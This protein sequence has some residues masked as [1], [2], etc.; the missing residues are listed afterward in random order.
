MVLLNVDWPW[1]M[2]RASLVIDN[3]VVVVLQ[4]FVRVTMILAVSEAELVLDEAACAVLIRVVEPQEK[5]ESPAKV[6]FKV[7]VCVL[8]ELIVPRLLL[9]VPE[10]SVMFAGRVSV[11]VTFW[12]GVLPVALT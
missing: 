9:K 8:P 6:A 1:V 2:F 3:N 12:A 5:L 4:L 11:A 7:T 10:D